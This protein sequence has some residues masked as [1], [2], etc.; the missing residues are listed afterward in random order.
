MSWVLDIVVSPRYFCR[1]CESRRKTI[2]ETLAN[3][4][5]VIKNKI[6]GS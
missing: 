5:Y 1:I 2:C 6:R 4:Q 3:K